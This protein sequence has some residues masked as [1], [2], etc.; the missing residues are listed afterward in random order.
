[1]VLTETTPFFSEDFAFF[2]QEVPGV[3]FFMGVSNESKGM[4]GLPHHPSFV[5]DEDA[6]SVGVRAMSL[7]IIEY[8]ARNL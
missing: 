2:Q 8:L 6:I 5:A 4:Q 3:M 1:M 7:V